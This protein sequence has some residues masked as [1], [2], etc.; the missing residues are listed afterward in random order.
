MKIAL[1]GLTYLVGIG[2]LLL[3]IYFWVTNSKSEIRRVMAFLALSLSLW[4]LFNGIFGVHLPTKLHSVI[5]TAPYVF[6]VFILSFLFHFSVVYPLKTFSFDR[7]HATFLY[8]IASI[9]SF[10]ILF[11][12]T[13]VDRF[14][15][16]DN[17][18]IGI[19]GGPLYGLYNFYLSVLMLLSLA[20]IVYKYR[21]IQGIPKRNVQ[22]ILWSSIITG[23]PAFITSVFHLA[24]TFPYNFLIGPIASGFWLV[25]V[26]VIIRRS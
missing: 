13:I 2:E 17:G 26:T 20:L 10:A 3:A 7:L 19:I 11:S 1:F 24:P 9:F 6:G 15:V 22:L 16:H 5:F 25:A 14:F 21:Q 18:S 8:A 4:V 12:T 23:V